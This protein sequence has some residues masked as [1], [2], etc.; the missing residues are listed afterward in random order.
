MDDNA[1]LKIPLSMVIRIPVRVAWLGNILFF[2]ASSNSGQEVTPS[3][4]MVHT[5][6]IIV[7]GHICTY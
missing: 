5:I 7:L 2:S 3:G 4:D 1:V 6:N